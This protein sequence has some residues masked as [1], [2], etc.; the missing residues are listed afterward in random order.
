MR[1]G[2]TDSSQRRSAGSAKTISRSARRLRVPSSLSTRCPKRSLIS[3][4]AGS[5]GST[6]SRATSSASTQGAPRAS[7]ARATVDFPEAMPP[8]TP[9]IMATSGLEK[10]E[11]AV[12]RHQRLAGQQRHPARQGQI[13][14]EG[15][16]GA[17][18][19]GQGKLDQYAD[20]GADPRRE[21][22]HQGE[23]LPAQPGTQRRH[24]LEVAVAHALLAGDQ[25]E[26][27]VEAP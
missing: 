22:Q 11:T 24:Q 23:G 1:G 21:N 20:D 26:G 5:P 3:A 14:A 12:G 8:V 16:G 6:T 17:A 15:H 19:A 18:Q 25:L 10:E 2:V 9:M 4:R 13:G 7:K 27:P